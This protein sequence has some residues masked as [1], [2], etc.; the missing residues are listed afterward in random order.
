MDGLIEDPLGTVNKVLGASAEALDNEGKKLW[1]GT[2]ADFGE[3]VTDVAAFWG[4]SELLGGTTKTPTNFVELQSINVVNESISA[5]EIA[6]SGGKHS[7]W[8]KTMS[9]LPT[10]ELQ[11]SITSIESNII[12]HQNLISNPV[13][14]FNENNKGNW[15]FLDPRQQQNLLKVKWPSDIQRA[16]E[17]I[18]ILQGII[19]K[20]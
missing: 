12:E 4:F 18:N 2:N 19:K 14:Y 16:K 15:K 9:D 17:Q 6:L 1:G 5:Y 8:L 20:K 13:K 11:R 3:V 10:S 7:G